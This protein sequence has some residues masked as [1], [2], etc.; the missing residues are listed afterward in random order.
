MK[1]IDWFNVDN[2]VASFVDLIA[3]YDSLFL[4]NDYIILY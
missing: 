4:M 2:M 3:R 1:M